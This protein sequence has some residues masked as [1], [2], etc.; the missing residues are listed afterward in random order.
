MREGDFVFGHERV[1]VPDRSPE[2]RNMIKRSLALA[3]ASAVLFVAPGLSPVQAQTSDT[4]L[5][6]TAAPTFDGVFRQTIAM[7]GLNAVGAKPTTAAVNWLVRQQ[8]ADGSFESYRADTSAPC[9]PGDPETFTGSNVQQTALA[10]I[11]LFQNNRSTQARRAIVWLI[12]SQNDDFGFPTF[13]GGVSDANS[14]GLALLALQTVQPQDRSARIPNA[15]RFLRTLQLR[16]ATGGGLAYQRGQ[17]A[18][19]V[20]SSQAYLGLVGGLPVQPRK[21]LKPNP[22][23]SSNTASNVGNY[24]AEPITKNGALANAFGPGPDY[25]STGF[26]ILGFVSDGVGRQAVRGG[27]RTLQ[28]NA[29]SYTQQDGAAVPAALGILLMVAHATDTNPASFGGINLVAALQR[30]ER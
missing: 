1:P 20:A 19:A 23:C 29:R 10:A 7:I 18:N 15:K 28:V 26:S 16:C 22:R 14:T 11:A 12:D 2:R 8:C 25:T 9:A 27:L 24:L 17:S 21:N 13:R 5:Y 3:I 30:S 6:G 4:G